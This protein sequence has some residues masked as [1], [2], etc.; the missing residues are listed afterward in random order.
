MI[1]YFIA[2]LIKTV[3]FLDMTPV[4]IDAANFHDVQVTNCL[5]CTRNEQKYLH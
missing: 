4:I 2:I 3:C 5:K 1:I